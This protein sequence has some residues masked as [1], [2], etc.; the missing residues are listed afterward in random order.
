MHSEMHKRGVPMKTND[1]IRQSFD[2]L[3]FQFEIHET[4]IER[5]S[6]EMKEKMNLVFE[7]NFHSSIKRK[8]IIPFIE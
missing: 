8:A 6:E 2:S 1:L 5:F 4:T 7:V 3:E